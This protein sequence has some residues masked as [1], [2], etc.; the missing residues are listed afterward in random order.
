MR[1][2][3][4]GVAALVMTLGACGSNTDK[5]TSVSISTDDGTSARATSSG[6]ADGSKFDVHSD[7]GSGRVK[8][9]APGFKLDVD[10]PKGIVDAGDF[11]IDGVKLYPGSKVHGMDVNAGDHESDTRVRI[12][13]ASPA[14]PAT[15][16]GW[17]VRQFAAKGHALSGDGMTLTGRSEDGKPFTVTLT[18][19]DAG[20]TNGEIVVAGDGKGAV[21]SRH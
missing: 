6:T 8:I 2:G 4:I 15:V 1:M 9:D 3:E 12:G 5:A 7:T 11:Q 19:G 10:V 18:Q 13:F 17:M 14:D 20:R 16:R 21:W